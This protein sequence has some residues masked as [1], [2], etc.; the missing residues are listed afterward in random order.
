MQT[1]LRAFDPNLAR[2]RLRGTLLELAAEEGTDPRRLPHTFETEALLALGQR[3]L[4]RRVV[5]ARPDFP[6][7]QEIT[8]IALSVCGEE[9]AAA[10]LF[11]QAIRAAGQEPEAARF[12]YLLAHY[13]HFRRGELADARRV[14]AE[15]IEEV[16]T[17]RVQK[18]RILLLAGRVARQVGDLESAERWYAHVLESGVHRYRPLAQLYLAIL[19]REQ[20]RLDDAIKLNRRAHAAMRRAGEELG[21]LMADSDLA[22]FHLQGGDIH[23]ARRLLVD[24]VRNHVDLLDLT[25][26]GNASNNLAMVCERLD[27]R[28]GARDA[29]LD[30]LRYHRA[31]GRKH[32]LAHTYRNLGVV[33]VELD[34]LEPALAAFERSIELATEI[35]SAEIELRGR[36]ETIEVLVHTGTRVDVIPRMVARCDRILATAEPGFATEGVLHYARALGRVIESG[37][38]RRGGG[39]RPGKLATAAGTQALETLTG[40]LDGEEFERLLRERIGPGLS[41]KDAP[42]ADQLVS[43]LLLFA[44]DYFRFRDFANEFHL[45]TGRVKHH[46]KVLV[47]RNVIELTGTKKAAKYSLSFHRAAV[48]PS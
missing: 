21:M 13:L 24:V 40:N 37:L 20:N 17:R 6:D 12:R 18:S 46:L 33:L 34:Q 47:E 23:E 5:R 31:V 4:R 39:G 9:E 11:E 42:D 1:F 7:I 36:T 19:R 14:L 15:A 22:A 8:G 25:A 10:E 3:T 27:D 38:L 44:G 30:S 45:T 41:G 35:A 43:F 29:Y 28:E 2:R 32:L 16:E 26:A 48:A